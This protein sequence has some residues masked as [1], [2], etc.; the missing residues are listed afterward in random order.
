MTEENTQHRTTRRWG[1]LFVT[2]CALGLI[3]FIGFRVLDFFI[4]WRTL[5]FRDFQALGF[6]IELNEPDYGQFVLTNRDG[7]AR[8]VVLTIREDY[9]YAGEGC[10]SHEVHVGSMESQEKR[11][12]SYAYNSPGSGTDIGRLEVWI[13][14]DR[15]TAYECCRWSYAR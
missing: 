5:F 13:R 15:G 9:S 12:C 6:S 7:R 1:C 11:T 4:P 3:G 2:V 8:D 14:C 10:T